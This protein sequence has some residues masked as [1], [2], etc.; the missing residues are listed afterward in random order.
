MSHAFNVN[1][2]FA[3]GFDLTISSSSGIYVLSSHPRITRDYST[4]I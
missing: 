2:K 1:V 3:T 4:G